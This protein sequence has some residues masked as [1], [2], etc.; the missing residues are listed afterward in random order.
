M[1]INEILN[2]P[3]LLFLFLNDNIH[4]IRANKIDMKIKTKNT[5]VSERGIIEVIKAKNVTYHLEKVLVK[6]SLLAVVKEQD[7]ASKKKNHISQNTNSKTD[8]GFCCS[9]NT[10]LVT[11]NNISK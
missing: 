9:S 1:N 8:S 11:W 5:S 3:S 6:N 10:D 2:T 4:L 7:K